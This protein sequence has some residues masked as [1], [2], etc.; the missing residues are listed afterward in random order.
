MFYLT[1][2]SFAADY[3]VW[4]P[5]R[6]SSGGFFWFDWLVSG[7]IGNAVS[8]GFCSGYKNRINKGHFSMIRSMFCD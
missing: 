2:D 6:H 7:W 5:S 1:S 4:G 3:G 8:C